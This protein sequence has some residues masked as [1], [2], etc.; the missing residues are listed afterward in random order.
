MRKGI[1]VSAALHIGVIGAALVTWPHALMLSDEPV[2]VIPVDLITV[3]DQSNVVPQVTEKPK[4]EPPPD[5]P[6]P[7]QTPVA[8]DQQIALAEVAPPP[9]PEPEPSPVTVDVAPKLQ[10]N[11]PTPPRPV[12]RPTPPRPRP[13]FSVD[14]VLALLDKRAKSA[15]QDEKNAVQ[16][17]QPRRGIGERNAETL[18]IKDALLAQMRQCWSPPV[19]APDPEKLIV[20]VRVFLGQNGDLAQPPRLS[21]AS[22]TAAAANPFM[23]TAAEAAL[24]AVNVCAPYRNLPPDRYDIWRDIEMTFDP[25]KMVGR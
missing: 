17:D 16:A 8:V 18:D 19:G 22:R 9:A 3:A 23:R 5:A 14:S 1:I 25:S 20:Q 24:R 7:V 2:P 10:P 4:P 6:Q 12:P 15:P 21:P 11:I 13:K